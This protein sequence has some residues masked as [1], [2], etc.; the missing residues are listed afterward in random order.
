MR[1]NGRGLTLNVVAYLRVSLH[2]NAVQ[3]IPVEDDLLTHARVR[4]AVLVRP[5]SGSCGTTA[6]MRQG[7]GESRPSF[8]GKGPSAARRAFRICTPASRR[9]DAASVCPLL[10]CAAGRR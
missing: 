5:R 3:Q 4:G 6:L 8:D 1:T 9:H 10:R 7:L 2:P